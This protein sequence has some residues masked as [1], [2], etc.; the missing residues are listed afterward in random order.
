MLVVLLG[1]VFSWA[2]LARVENFFLAL[3]ATLVVVSGLNYA[4]RV[5]KA[6]PELPSKS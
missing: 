6:L 1:S 2:W 3:T 5:G 4:Y